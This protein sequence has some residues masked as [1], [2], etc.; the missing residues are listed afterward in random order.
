MIIIRIP[1]PVGERTENTVEPIKPLKRGEKVRVLRGSMN[2]MILIKGKSIPEELFNR[3][4]VLVS[5]TE[6]SGERYN[7][8][9]MREERRFTRR[10]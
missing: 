4:L 2:N 1:V 7:P 9:L 3:H 6:W 8:D 5:K 10:L